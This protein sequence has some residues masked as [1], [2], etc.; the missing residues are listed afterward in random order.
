MPL[1]GL[2]VSFEV[3]VFMRSYVMRSSGRAVGMPGRKRTTVAKIAQ[4]LVSPVMSK[5]Y[6]Q[7]S[8][9]GRRATRARDTDGVPLSRGKAL[10][11]KSV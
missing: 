2:F 10:E 9:S 7:Q 4:A 1:F 3:L 5:G 11:R 8:D 6:S